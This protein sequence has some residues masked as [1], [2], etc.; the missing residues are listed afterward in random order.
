MIRPLIRPE[1]AAALRR[2]RGRALAAGAGAA[3]LVLLGPA[4][5]R[6]APLALVALVVILG[7]AA[8]LYR[9]ARN[10]ARLGARGGPGVVELR[11]GALAYFGPEEGG[12]MALDDLRAVGLAPGAEGPVWRLEAAER[13]LSI[14]AN[15]EGAEA[16][17]DAFAT[18]P[19]F[20]AGRLGRALGEGRRRPVAIWRRPAP[21]RARL[22]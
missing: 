5:W 16:L 4:A 11:E 8:A 12:A 3:A 14:P 6:G 9:D 19:G 2:W 7:A 17:L 1:A 13:T 15:A 10:R 18:L 20:E 22:R 21:D